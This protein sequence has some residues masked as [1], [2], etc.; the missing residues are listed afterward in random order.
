MLHL[1]SNQLTLRLTGLNRIHF[2]I[3]YK[4]KNWSVR[5]DREAAEGTW[6]KPTAAKRSPHQTIST[7]MLKDGYKRQHL[8]F[9]MKLSLMRGM[10]DNDSIYG[11]CGELKLNIAFNVARNWN[12][13]W[14]KARFKLVFQVFLY[15]KTAHVYFIVC[16][17]YTWN[18]VKCVFISSIKGTLATAGTT[19]RAKWKAMPWRIHSV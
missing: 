11:K 12:V 9:L 5:A 4:T 8:T 10:T 19:L 16:K 3:Y 17:V 7:V 15:E 14:A 18:C 2:R 13:I 1:V 6:D